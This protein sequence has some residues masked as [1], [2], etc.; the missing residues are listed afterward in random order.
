MSSDDLRKSWNFGQPIVDD[1]DYYRDDDKLVHRCLQPYGPSA[2]VV[3]VLAARRF[4]KTSF[5]KRVERWAEGGK[6][7]DPKVWNRI[8]FVNGN[9]A[10]DAERDLSEI[11]ALLANSEALATARGVLVLIDEF[12]VVQSSENLAKPMER[13]L[14]DALNDKFGREELRVVI[15]EASNME[16]LIL[17]DGSKISTS[18]ARLLL[19][20]SDVGFI[21][22]L[23]NDEQRKLI[24]HAKRQPHEPP[25][26][27]EALLEYANNHPLYLQLVCKA[28]FEDDVTS[29]PA[30]VEWMRERGYQENIYKIYTDLSCE[31][32]LVLRYLLQYGRA[33]CDDINDNRGQDVLMRLERFG[34]VCGNEDS[35]YSIRSPILRSHMESLPEN[36]KRLDEDRSSEVISRWADLFKTQHQALKDHEG[37]WVIHHLGNLHIP[38]DDDLGGVWRAYRR[39]LDADRPHVVVIAGDLLLRPA[40]EAHEE[41]RRRARKTFRTIRNELNQIKADFLRRIDQSPDQVILVPGDTDGFMRPGAGVDQAEQDWDEFGDIFEWE[42]WRF[43][44]DAPMMLAPMNSADL[45]DSSEPE[46]REEVGVSS[47]VSR[48]EYLE[49]CPEPGSK[50][51]A[52][53]FKKL[54]QGDF[55]YL[56]KRDLNGINDVIRDLKTREMIEEFEHSLRIAVFHHHLEQMSH[57]HWVD[58]WNSHEA[59]RLLARHRFSLVLSSHTRPFSHTDEVR[60]ETAQGGWWRLHTV[61][62]GSMS[63]ALRSEIPASFNKIVVVIK[64]VARARLGRGFKYEFNVAV[65]EVRLEGDTFVEQLA[66]QNRFV[67]E[68]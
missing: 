24:T 8:F 13:L 11:V 49:S 12:N 42:K 30:F 23:S 4:G 7:G 45:P 36:S 67:V 21:R 58:F 22:S 38:F 3:R 56:Q 35:S 43:F 19:E 17:G 53:H 33:T 16:D 64:P 10:P 48:W 37:R 2:N 65:T 6:A 18:V 20:K 40:N 62:C 32:K 27:Q 15:A 9:S 57:S 63:D 60:D 39:Y 31:E 68:R 25:G 26:V 44:D 29:V 34:L 28:Y 66:T 5:L 54:Q 41:E 1:L 59:K 46:E 47:I 50:A 14:S 52:E 55:G 51:F 61:S